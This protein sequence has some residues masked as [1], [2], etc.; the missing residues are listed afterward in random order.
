MNFPT[1]FE[2]MPLLPYGQDWVAARDAWQ[3]YRRGINADDY[4]GIW[5]GLPSSEK[6]MWLRIAMTTREFY[7]KP[8]GSQP[9][10]R[11][12]IPL[13]ENDDQ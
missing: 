5:R 6:E 7:N 9:G 3:I 10:D 2:G 4:I 11:L 1:H 12:F 8:F 13:E